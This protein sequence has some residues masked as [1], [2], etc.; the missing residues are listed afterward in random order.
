MAVTKTK[1][2]RQITWNGDDGKYGEKGG[3][4]GI[5]QLLISSG[6]RTD[7]WWSVVAEAGDDSCD[8]GAVGWAAAGMGARA[9]SSDRAG[10]DADTGVV[11]GC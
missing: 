11:S 1:S 9:G 8:D 2:G 3:A 4:I 10:S 6:S 7:G 5:Q